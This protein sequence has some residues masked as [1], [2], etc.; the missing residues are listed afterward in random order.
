MISDTDYKRT[1]FDVCNNHA[2]AKD[3]NQFVPAMKNKV[4]RFEVVDED[5]W[6]KRLNA[7]LQSS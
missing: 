2:K 7:I 1:V 5:E 3:W 4:V 6:E